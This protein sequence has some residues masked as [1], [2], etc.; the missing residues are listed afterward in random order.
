MFTHQQSRNEIAFCSRKICTCLQ[1]GLHA[2]AVCGDALANQSS[3]ST[4]FILAA[5]RA[6]SQITRRRRVGWILAESKLPTTRTSL[7]FLC[8]QLCSDW[9]TR[10]RLPMQAISPTSSKNL[11][12]KITLRI[13]ST[14]NLINNF[15]NNLEVILKTSQCYSTL[16]KW[17]WNPNSFERL[18]LGPFY[19]RLAMQSPST[20]GYFI[21]LC[22]KC[23]L[24][25][26]LQ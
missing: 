19:G 25:G 21:D 15:K 5:P 2:W 8:W 4:P 7:F 3:D 11:P 10:S 14:Q 26:G 9:Q 20:C 6:S 23:C 1:C 24:L 18:L 22:S 17:A 16:F 12:F 13:D